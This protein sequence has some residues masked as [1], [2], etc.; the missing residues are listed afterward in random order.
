MLR[1]AANS[2]QGKISCSALLRYTQLTDQLIEEET[3]AVIV[4]VVRFSTPE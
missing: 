4:H 2:I 3:R 1:T